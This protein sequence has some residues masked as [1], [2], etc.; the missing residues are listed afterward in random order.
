MKT[1]L[2]YSIFTLVLFSSISIAQTKVW[3]F[4]ND[5]TN[6]P[7]DGTGIAGNEI[8]DNLGIYMG[9]SSLNNIGIIEASPKTFPDT[10][11][12]ANR[13]KLNGA[14]YSGSTFQAM[15][16]Q[17]Y[18]Y[19]ATAGNCTITVWF[20]TGGSGTRTLYVTDGS[21]IVGSLAGTNSSD[22]LILQTTYTGGAT[23]LYIYGDQSSNLYKIEVTGALGTTTLDSD[24]FKNGLSV[25]VYGADNQIHLSNITSETKVNVY[26]LTGQ[27][28]K[29][30]NTSIDTNF[31]LTK[32]FYIINMESNEGKKSVKII[33]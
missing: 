1:K 28:I 19:F 5:T 27:L 11:A 33:L 23:N 8:N 2:L 29:S 16:T 4:G 31:E 18:V 15:P 12:G 7:L 22:G 25:N 10:Y 30:L 17:R 24:A 20:R 14:G 9:V 21:S 6:W 26:S 32:G 3:D 13:F